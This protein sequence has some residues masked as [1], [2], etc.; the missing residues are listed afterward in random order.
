MKISE[1]CRMIEESFHS[2]KYPLEYQEQKNFAK[3]VKITNKSE[4]DDL[5]SKDIKIEVR[6]ENLFVLNN[7]VP[8]IEHLPGIIEMDILDSFKILCRRIGRI[9]SDLISNI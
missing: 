9:S 5:K 7:Y 2:E 8:D 4:S 1:L 6:I 3:L